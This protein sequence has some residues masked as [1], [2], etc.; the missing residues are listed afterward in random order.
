VIEES[1]VLSFEL[2]KRRLADIRL[3]GGLGGEFFSQDELQLSIHD[4]ADGMLR[5]ADASEIGDEG[6]VVWGFDLAPVKGEA[7]I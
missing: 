4:K 5:A 2:V 3:R 6:G 7:A 1:E